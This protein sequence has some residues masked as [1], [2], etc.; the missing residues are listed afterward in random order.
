VA[1]NAN[2]QGVVV[3]LVRAVEPGQE[4]LELLADLLAR[5][6]RLVGGQQGRP[7]LLA[8]L[9][10]VI[11]LL[12][13][14]DDLADVVVAGEVAGDLGL[15]LLGV[16]EQTV[17][18]QAQVGGRGQLLEQGDGGPRVVELGD[19]VGHV[20]DEAHGVH[21][22][23]AEPQFGQRLGAR[24]DPQLALPPAHP[25]D[26]LRPGGV[27]RDRDRPG[28]RHGHGHAGQSHELAHP[29]PLHDLAHA[30]R[31]G[32]PVGVRLGPAQQEVRRPGGV[33]HQAHR[34]PGRVVALVVVAEERQRG[35][36]GAV[37]V[38]RVDVE[39]RHHLATTLTGGELVEVVGRESRGVA[40][41]EE[42][43]QDD[44]EHGGCPVEL[45]D[46]VDDVHEPLGHRDSFVSQGVE[47]SPTR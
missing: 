45:G 1:G 15:G 40:G 36:P 39:G 18:G 14:G 35:A 31:E 20:G 3:G 34:E 33:L 41:V 27:R 26:Q 16:A 22:P 47:P 13:A 8:E 6:Q 46:V 17:D 12:Q 5:W 28:V 25:V 37:V 30:A 11:L 38:E 32:L 10:G 19:V 2:S 9:E 44:D 42:A 4:T 23:L 29:E 24:R 43:V 21:A 7:G